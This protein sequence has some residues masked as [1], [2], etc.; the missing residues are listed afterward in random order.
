MKTPHTHISITWTKN[1]MEFP[2]ENKAHQRME[3]GE[4]GK[5]EFLEG[6]VAGRA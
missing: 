2:D 4:S 6:G 3:N 1:S 5:G